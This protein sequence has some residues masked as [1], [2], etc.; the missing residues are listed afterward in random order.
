[1]RKYIIYF[2]IILQV[3][4]GFMG[5]WSVLTT[6]Q[7]YRHLPIHLWIFVFLP[8]SMFFLGII[9]GLAFLEK[10]KLGIAL[11]SIYQMLQIP[12]VSSPLLSYR[13]LSGLILGIGWSKNKPVVLA[14]FGASIIVMGFRNTDQWIIGVNMLAL[15]LLIYLLL[16]LRRKKAIF[17]R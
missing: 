12:I 13:F 11:S 8:V 15:F 7:W 10:P 1:M 2:L 5:I 17:Q 4:G 14:E 9:A 16:Q 6:T 3:G